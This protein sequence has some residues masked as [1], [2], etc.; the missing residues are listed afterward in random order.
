MAKFPD[1]PKNREVYDQRPLPMTWLDRLLSV[2]MP[3][4]AGPQ[5]RPRLENRP[6]LDD[7]YIVNKLLR[8]ESYITDDHTV[9][10][11]NF[12]DDKKSYDFVIP[13]V[14]HPGHLE[15]KDRIKNAFKEKK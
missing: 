3:P 10:I 11:R 12:K 8:G 4:G 2:L 7:Q 6:P 14:G 15:V 5:P 1:D 13:G 9:H